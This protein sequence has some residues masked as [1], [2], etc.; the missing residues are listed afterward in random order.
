MVRVTLEIPVESLREKLLGH[1]FE[2]INHIEEDANVQLR[3]RVSTACKASTFHVTGRLFNLQRQ[4]SSQGGLA[5]DPLYFNIRA[6]QAHS[7]NIAKDLIRDL[8]RAI[9]RAAD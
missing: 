3:L 7:I 6:K 1:S 2:N 9:S 8:A 5:K 4:F